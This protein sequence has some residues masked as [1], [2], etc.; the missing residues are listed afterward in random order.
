MR[1]RCCVI[2]HNH[3]GYVSFAHQLMELADCIEEVRSTCHFCNKKAVF[4]LKHVNGRADTTGPGKCY[5]PTSVH[6]TVGLTF[7]SSQ[8]FSWAL[9]RSI[10]RLVSLATCSVWTQQARISCP[11]LYGEGHCRLW[12]RAN[13]A[14]AMCLVSDEHQGMQI[15]TFEHRKTVPY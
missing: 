12:A 15:H 7:T 11:C 2:I 6:A 13:G 3:V 5:T 9:R 14:M 1:D 10:S 8:L 4:N